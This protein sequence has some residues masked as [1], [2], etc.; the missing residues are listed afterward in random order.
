[1]GGGG[2]GIQWEEEVLYI[3]Y[4][5]K[6]T[7]L[8]CTTNRDLQQLRQQEKERDKEWCTTNFEHIEQIADFRTRDQL[9][10]RRRLIQFNYL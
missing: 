4:K 2:T 1:M 3:K 9:C 8:Q 6:I 10:R 5:N 7:T